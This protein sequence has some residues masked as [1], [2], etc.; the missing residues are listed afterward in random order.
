MTDERRPWLEGNPDYAVRAEPFCARVEIRAEIG[1]R[2]VVLAESDRALLVRETD[3]D[4]VLYL[5]RE[6]VRLELLEHSETTTRCPFKG[7]AAY[8]SVRA[9]GAAG[10]A[11]RNVA[12][13]Y[14]APFPEIAAIAGYLAFDRKR[15]AARVDGRPECR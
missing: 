7:D 12:W 13:S 9:P 10:P 8:W 11:V 6:D 3:H 14:E 4:P 15:V 2:E 1:G 5:P